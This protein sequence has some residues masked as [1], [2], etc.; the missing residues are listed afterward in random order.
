MGKPGP[1]GAWDIIKSMSVTEIAREANRPLS[2]AVVGP[3]SVRAE[4]MRALFQPDAQDTLALPSPSALPE[5]AFVQGYDTLTEEAKFPKQAGV[6]DFVID[7][8][9]TSREN[10]PAG[11][12][13]YSVADLG[14]W[15]AMLD[16]ILEDKPNLVM[17][18]A[19]NFPVFR[20]RAAQ[21]IIHDTATANAQFSLVTG[22]AEAFPILREIGFPGVV[23]SDVFILTKNQT[24]MTLRLA[25]AYGLPLDYKSRLK[26]VAPIL[27]NAFGWRAVARELVG[28]IPVVGFLAKPAIAYAGTATVGKTAQ[29]YYE[30]GEQVTSAQA[31]KIYKEAYEVGKT[32]VRELA[33]SMRRGKGGGG[34]SKRIPARA[35]LT[36]EEAAADFEYTTGEGEATFP[37]NPEPDTSA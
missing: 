11:L 14:G 37:A 34:G 17:A 20:R 1:K 22:V 31:R 36:Q 5:P 12:T 10:I 24:L 28:L 30:T 16:R 25:A 23:L 6:Y 21:K 19:R 13:V 29:L 3:E 35:A 26:E 27:A 33:S 4:A 15:D 9:N 8:G 32:R 2:V 7:V 18:L